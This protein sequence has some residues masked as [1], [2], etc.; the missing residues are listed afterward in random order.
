MSSIKRIYVAPECKDLSLPV[1]HGDQPDAVC[2]AGS[3]VTRGNNTCTEGGGAAYFCGSG[4]GHG[5]YC[6]SGGTLVY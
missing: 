6:S 2:E 1:V 5:W 4:T 3:S